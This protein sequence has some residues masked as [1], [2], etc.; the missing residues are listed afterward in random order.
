M[1][2]VISRDELTTE[3]KQDFFKTSRIFKLISPKRYL[4]CIDLQKSSEISYG[5]QWIFVF[6]QNYL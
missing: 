1:H 6:E 5:I 3:V 4:C 2:V